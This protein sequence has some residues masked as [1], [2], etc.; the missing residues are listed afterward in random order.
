[1]SECLDTNHIDAFS[2]LLA[3]KNRL[4]PGL[5]TPFLFI[6]SC[7]WGYVQ[8]KVDTT[9]YVSHITIESVRAAKYLL[10]PIIQDFH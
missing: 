6:S 9:Q 4:C 5:F 3:E 1:M 2:I 7:H 10:V 8:H